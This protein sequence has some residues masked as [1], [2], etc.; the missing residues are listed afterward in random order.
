[1]SSQW[2]HRFR[3]WFEDG[4]R[5]D[6]YGQT[7]DGSARSAAAAQRMVGYKGP[8]TRPVRT[9]DLGHAGSDGE[10]CPRCRAALAAGRPVRPA[11]PADCPDPPTEPPGAAV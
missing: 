2:R 3:V 1:M 10:W 8:A 5:R 7:P 11:T 4:T 6:M 9:Q